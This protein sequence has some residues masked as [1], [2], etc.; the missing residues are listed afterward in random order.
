MVQVTHGPMHERR[1]FLLVCRTAA[2]L[3]SASVSMA[4]STSTTA[5]KWRKTHGPE[6]CRLRSRE[7]IH[8]LKGQECKG[9]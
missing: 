5:K 1:V 9:W 4:Q 7:G 3:L 8:S 2:A 6:L